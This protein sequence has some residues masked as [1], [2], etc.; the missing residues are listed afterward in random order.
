MGQ[1]YPFYS[2]V[3]TVLSFSL[4]CSFLCFA[5]WPLQNT[6]L[7]LPGWKANCWIWP[8]RC[9]GNILKCV[10]RERLAYISPNP[11]PALVPVSGKNDTPPVSLRTLLQGSISILGSWNILTLALGILMSSLHIIII[12]KMYLFI[13]LCQVLVAA[14]GI[15][16]LHCG[17]WDL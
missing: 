15:F 6:S 12:F 17:M 3:P 14:H 7:R 5:Q 10:E 16:H 1:L 13:W 4:F 11:L 2:L 8:V 9:S